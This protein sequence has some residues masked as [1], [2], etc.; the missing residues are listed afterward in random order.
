MSSTPERFIELVQSGEYIPDAT[1]RVTI[2]PATW[3]RWIRP[4]DTKGLRWFDPTQQQ[5]AVERRDLVALARAVDTE[6]PITIR[7]LFVATM[8]WGSGPWNG[9]GPRYTAQA[10]SDPR[11]ADTLRDTRHSIL[12]NSPE[13]AYARFKVKGVGPS[14]FTKWFW[15]A[16]LA[17]NLRITPLVL[18]ER[19]WA[20]LGALSWNSVDAA[21]GSRLRKRRYRAY[22]DTCALWAAD[23]PKL[24]GG[25]E[26]VENVLF[27]WAGG[28]R[29]RRRG[30]SR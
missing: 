24:F 19:V 9:R 26:D 21:G 18:D 16:G 23:K 30:S 17:S 2:Y 7:R 20:S 1:K 22:L 27:Q 25:P 5:V 4:E 8:M 10:L 11:L 6:D 15:A 28:R 3:A 14:F 13:D 29:D 12:R